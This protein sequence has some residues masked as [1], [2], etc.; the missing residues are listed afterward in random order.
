MPS[1]APHRSIRRPNVALLLLLSALVPDASASA[2]PTTPT[3]ITPAATAPTPAK[4]GSASNSIEIK[5]VVVTGQRKSEKLQKAPVSVTVLTKPTIDA[6]GVKRAEDIIALT[7]GASLVA[8]TAEVGD[9]QLN[10]RGI[11]SARDAGSSF[12]FVVDGIQEP[13]PSTFNREFADLQQ[14]EVLK[15]PQGAIYG[16]N[17]EAGAVV[18]TTVTPTNTLQASTT[19]G[20]GDF[21]TVYNQSTVSGA[22]I[23]NVL[24]GR[25]S[26][27]YRNTDGFYK[28]SFYDNYSVDDYRNY[29]I[30]G[31]LIY[32]PSEDW[33]FDLKVRSGLTDAA[34][35]FYDTVF[36]L[37]ALVPVFGP[38]V[39]EDV[40]DHQFH[41]NENIQP[42]NHQ[43][44]QEVSLKADHSLTWAKLTAYVDY[45]SVNS[46]LLSDGTLASFGF[47]NNANNVL[48]RNVCAS[49][50]A[51]VLAS[52]FVYPAP[53]NPAFGFLG[54]YTPSTCDGYQYQVRD[55]SDISTELRFS[56]LGAGPLRWSG[57]LY[58]LHSERHVGVSVGDDLGF[59][60]NKTLD[61][62][63]DTTSPTAQLYNDDFT[64]DVVAG[65]GSL[66]YDIR[67]NL[68]ISAALRYDTEFKSDKNLVPT[69]DLQDYI[70]I[71]SGGPA[72]SVFFPLNPGLIANPRGIPE[73]SAVF[74]QPEPKLS[75]DWTPQANLTL[76]ATAG[77]GFKA[78]GFNSAGTQATVAKIAE[79]SGSDVKVGDAYG[80]ETSNAFEV[81]MK[82]RLLGTQLSYQAA[83][84][85]TIV[86]GMQFNEFFS[87]GEGLL[88]VDSNIDRV[89]LQGG[90]LAA[91]Y[92]PLSWLVFSGGGDVTGSEIVK[93]SSRP[94]TVGN[95]SPY[96]P[97][98]TATAAVSIYRP[99]TERF[100]L[101]GRLDTNFVGP[102]WFHTV[103]RQSVPTIDGV[104]GYYGGAERQAFSTS[105]LRIGVAGPRFELVAFVRNLFNR[106]YL[107]EVIPAPEFGGSFASEGARRLIGGELTVHY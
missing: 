73:K 89:D 106:H 103:Q 14:I 26:V 12:A 59:S 47:F 64:S 87:S 8:G 15:G 78:G 85:Y 5:E 25:L 46:N 40:N 54:A 96:T 29:D 13:D 68:V 74:D 18:V 56:S 49:S 88:R 1:H 17:A 30:D 23:P 94:D 48:G 65:F 43:D 71:D 81:G 10:I 92:R 70:N 36:E 82:G 91:Q 104:N 53:Q 100:S 80:K 69:G 75:L 22:I 58:Y 38:A 35:I 19:T 105:N 51:A 45:S 102:T 66:D 84:Y 2:D 50:Q 107:A 16:R 83:A 6:A 41:Y 44:T 62:P 67:P 97:A 7:P 37:P 28:N 98:Y 76:Y 101:I 21:N 77:I 57:G 32:T 79:E 52:G 9:V 90:E 24:V 95:K 93:N 31:R 55:E 4:P 61:N 34:S 27:D 60:I 99:V 39:N 20:I 11:N 72:D 86:N 42:D 63:I 33:T 3:T